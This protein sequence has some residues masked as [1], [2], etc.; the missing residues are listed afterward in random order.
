MFMRIAPELYA[1]EP[2]L[3]RAVAVNVRFKTTDVGICRFLKMMIVGQ[4]GKVVCLF[5]WC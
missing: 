5:R 1:I 4:F 3:T 2:F